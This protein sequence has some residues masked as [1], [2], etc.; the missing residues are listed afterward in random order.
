MSAHEASAASASSSEADVCIDVIE[1]MYATGW[2]D[3]LP[4]VPPTRSRVADFVAASGRRAEELIGNIPPMGGQAT[5]QK[6]AA[7]AVMAGCRPE[8]MPVLIAAV[9]ALLDRSVNVG[10]M[11]CSMHDSIPLLIINGPIRSKLNVNARFNVFGQGWRANATI[12]RA[13]NLLLVN[14]GGAKPGEADRSTFGQPGNFAFCIAENEEESPFDPLHVDRGFKREESTVTVIGTEAPHINNNATAENARD[15]LLTTVSMMTNR[16]AM[17]SYLQGEL[18]VCLGPEH[19]KIIASEGWKK[20]DVQQFLFEHARNPIRE[21]KRG[22]PY[23]SDV[24]RY[25]TWPRWVDRTDDDAMVPVTR[26][27]SDFLVL[28]AGGPGK[29]TAYLPSWATR[30]ATRRIEA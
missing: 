30:S 4:L 18:V 5:V 29:Q 8:Y 2:S 10:G 24:Q 16:G 26:R 6:I 28:V 15:V 20:V 3:G 1:R 13:V 21:L 19:A 22:G 9:D 11:I 12:G 25:K 17:N 14:L 7:N 23:G 27:A